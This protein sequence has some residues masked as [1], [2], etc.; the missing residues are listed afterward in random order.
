MVRNPVPRKKEVPPLSHQLFVSAAS[1]VHWLCCQTMH[2]LGSFGST[3]LS[4]HSSDTVPWLHYRHLSGA[5]ARKEL[6]VELKVG[7]SSSHPAL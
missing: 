3:T 5:G 4:A 7:V 1:P 6:T 2:R